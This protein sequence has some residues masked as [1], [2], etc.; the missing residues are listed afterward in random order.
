MIIFLKVLNK[1]NIRALI[2]K[3]FL[4]IDLF[5]FAKLLELL[6]IDHNS[7]EKRIIFTPQLL[8]FSHILVA[9]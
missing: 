1:A 2:P 7:P 4:I 8:K 5:P 6:A 9:L 3:L